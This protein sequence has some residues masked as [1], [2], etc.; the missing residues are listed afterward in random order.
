MTD[1]K[2]IQTEVKSSEIQSM[3]H[4]LAER[5]KYMIVNGNKLQDKEIFALAQ[6]AATTGLDPFS[7][8]CWYFPD[9]GPT[10]GIAGW[11]RKG[12]EQLEYEAQNAKLSG[13]YVW[14]EYKKAEPGSC[15]FD[16]T[17]DIAYKVILHDSVSEKLWQQTLSN[18]IATLNGSSIRQ[19]GDPIE[20]YLKIVEMARSMMPPIPTWEAYGV[21]FSSENFGAV[22]KFDRHERAKKRGEKGVLKKRFPRLRLPE[23]IGFDND[24]V[25]SS[26]FKIVMSEPEKPSEPTP[27]E[28]AQK[29]IEHQKF[30]DAFPGGDPS[31]EKTIDPVNIVTENEYFATVE[32]KGLTPLE[33]QAILNER[34]GDY[35]DA[36]V[37][38]N[39]RNK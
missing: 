23:P 9:K 35:N 39:K 19:A 29:K 12:Q 30:I 4:D 28:M 20:S 31:R 38:L 22:E 37:H 26:D 5:M 3:A 15:N 25:D 27:A 2:A 14:Y 21:V 1:Q 6:Y 33:G 36:M 13:A 16:P 32:A 17:K 10:P 11:R 7:G 34:G 18:L 8:E 24:V